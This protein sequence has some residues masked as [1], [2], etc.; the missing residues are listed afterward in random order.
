MEWQSA[1]RELHLSGGLRLFNGMDPEVFFQTP[2]LSGKTCKFNIPSYGQLFGFAK[3]LGFTVIGCDF[4]TSE[5]EAKEI[6][7]PQWRTHSAI[8]QKWLCTEQGQEWSFIAHAAFLQK[9]GRLCDI[10]SRISHQLRACEWRLRQLSNSYADQ[11]R[12]RLHQKDFDPGARFK[13]GYTSLC[14]LALHSFLMDACVLRDYLAEFYWEAIQDRAGFEE[15]KIT[16]LS[17]LL[18]HWKSNSPTDKAGKEI[19]ATSK[20]GQWLHELGEYRNLVVHIAP[21][22]HAGQSLFAVTRT[23]NMPQGQQQPAVKLPLPND[24]VSLIE[25]RATG[26]YFDDPE[27]NFARFSGA[28]SDTDNCRDSLEY[29]HV[30][31]Q[32]LGSMARSVSESSPLRPEVP[33]ITPKAGT[34][35]V[36]IK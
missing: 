14:Y 36:E 20:S 32:L 4:F 12:S 1:L 15:K 28:F 13:D 26:R 31:M 21:L 5:E 25:E 17:G 16:T 11:L 7:P 27:L 18:R 23:F 33:I 30:C 3:S 19:L 6:H 10:S 9:K 22:A 2:T 8:N 24:P 34:F 29:A 35:K